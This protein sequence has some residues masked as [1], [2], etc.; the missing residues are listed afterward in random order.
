MK[1]QRVHVG[2]PHITRPEAVMVSRVRHVPHSWAS[3]SWEPEEIAGPRELPERRVTSPRPL[4]WPIPRAAPDRP[5]KMERMVLASRCLSTQRGALLATLLPAANPTASGG[6][7]V[8][9]PLW[10]TEAMH[11]AYSLVTLTHLLDRRDPQ[12]ECIPAAKSFEH[13]NALALAQ[14][15]CDL[16]IADDSEWFACSDLLRTISRSLV[17]LFGPAIGHIAVR[18]SLPRLSLPAIKRRALVLACSELVVN[19]LRHAFLYWSHGSIVV[20]LT[21]ADRQHVRLSVADDGVGVHVP[22]AADRFGIAADLALLLEGELGYRNPG[23]GGTTA[24][25]TFPTA[26][27]S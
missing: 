20:A 22:P 25:I 8:L 18:T 21:P 23:L 10:A 17:E 16:E 12:R 24:E 15:Y 4:Q 2:N 14:A 19:S 1:L 5:A 13:K 27:C 26:V 9:R 7:A 6:R 11:R 3:G